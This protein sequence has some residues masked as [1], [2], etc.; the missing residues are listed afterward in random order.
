MPGHDRI[1]FAQLECGL[2]FQKFT[3]IACVECLSSGDISGDHQSI[4]VWYTG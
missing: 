1:L 3:S 2:I 4:I